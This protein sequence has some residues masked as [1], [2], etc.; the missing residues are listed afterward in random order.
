[1]VTHLLPSELERVCETCL[2]PSLPC[3]WNEKSL[4]IDVNIHS[5]PSEVLRALTERSSG[6]I[7]KQSSKQPLNPNLSCCHCSPSWHAVL[8]VVVGEFTVSSQCPRHSVSEKSFRPSLHSC[9]W[10]N[11]AWAWAW[12]WAAASNHRPVISVLAS[13]DQKTQK[14]LFLFHLLPFMYTKNNGLTVSQH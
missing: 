6:Q 14:H 8:P 13:A 1:M 5:L 2:V 9:W 4:R 10:I 3:N 11:F 12:A 7:S